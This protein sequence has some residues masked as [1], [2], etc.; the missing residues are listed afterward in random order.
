M[1]LRPLMFVLPAIFAAAPAAAQSFDRAAAPATVAP[2]AAT[3][4]AS[5]SAIGFRAYFLQD[6]VQ[7]SASESF[8]AVFGDHALSGPGVGGEVL[9]LWR[10]VFARVA[11]ASMKKDGGTRVVVVNGQ[12]IPTGIG[13]DVEMKP[14]EFG[15]GWRQALDPAGRFVAYG[16]ASGLRIKYTETSEF[17]SLDEN[18]D[19]TL[20]GYAVFAGIDVA[21]W[22]VLFAG[23]EFQYRAIP[24]AIGAG[25]VSAEFG[26]TD[27]GGTAFRVL[28][29]IRR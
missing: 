28:V 3:Q 15:A 20:N 18:V 9:N 6:W 16:G 7:M 25:G 11:F 23:A 4:A 10:G 26:E 8:D 1:R 29:G 27:L 17:A 21:V 19:E 24:D 13:F 2:A 14:L 12:V 5:P 22:R